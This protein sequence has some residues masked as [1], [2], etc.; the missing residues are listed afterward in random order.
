M[1]EM[2]SAGVESE[3][4]TH[5]PRGDSALAAQRSW[6]DEPGHRAWLHAGLADVITFALGSILP[7]GGFAYQA[8]DGSPSTPRRRAEC[9]SR[10]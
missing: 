3:S 6:L 5:K 10:M 9:A 4:S 1:S 2:H 8:A 7:D